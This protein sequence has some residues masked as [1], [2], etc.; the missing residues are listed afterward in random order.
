MPLEPRLPCAGFAE[1]GKVGRRLRADAHARARQ[2]QHLLH[3][4]LGER[5]K[6]RRPH[7]L[8]SFCAKRTWRPLAPSRGCERAD[9]RDWTA[10]LERIACQSKCQRA[11]KA[12]ARPKAALRLPVA[13]AA[14]GRPQHRCDRADARHGARSSRTSHEE[15]MCGGRR[16]RQRG[17]RPRSATPSPINVSEETFG[18]SRGTPEWGFQP[19]PPW[20]ARTLMPGASR[21]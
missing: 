1:H 14:V 5:R 19:A 16:R 17:R 9:A 15:P 2:P 4:P 8:H 7:G 21:S 11:P 12:P 3:A 20:V 13:A 6:M 18:Y 10:R